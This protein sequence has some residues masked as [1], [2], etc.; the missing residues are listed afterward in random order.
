MPPTGKTVNI[1]EFH[2]MRVQDDQI[3]EY[4]AEF[5]TLGMLQQLGVI[6]A[7]APAA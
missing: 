4:W 2:V 7:A 1:G 6:P 3:A 5:D